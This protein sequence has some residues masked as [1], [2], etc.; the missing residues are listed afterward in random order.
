M[1]NVMANTKHTSIC[2][3]RKLYLEILNQENNEI[4]DNIIDILMQNEYDI[5][6]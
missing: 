2:L 1:N 6:L 3:L 5:C 4:I